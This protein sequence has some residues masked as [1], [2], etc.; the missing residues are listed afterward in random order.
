[1]TTKL[2]SALL[3]ATAMWAQDAPFQTVCSNATLEGDYGFIITGM[4]PSGPG[5]PVETI[6]GIAMTHFDGN[7]NLTQTDNIHGSISG[8][9]TPN[10]PGTGTYTI[11]SDCSGTMKLIN[12]GAPVLTLAIAVVDDG[13]TVLTAVQDPTASVAAGTSPPQV[14][15][16][17]QGRRVVNR[18]S[19]R[20]ADRNAN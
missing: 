14:M 8:V 20:R 6:V 1:M 12:S 15:V 2:G 4:R 16:T 10:R 17:S 5:G 7:G 11:N 3:F 9:A 18:A 19:T 13:N